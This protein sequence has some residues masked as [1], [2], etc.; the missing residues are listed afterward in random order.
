MSRFTFAHVADLHLDTPFSGL[1]ALNDAL[2]QQLQDASLLAWDRVVD[3]CLAEQVTFVVIAGDVYDSDTASVRAQLRF[4]RGLERLS[5]A[6]IPSF[7]VHG[8]HDPNGGRWSAVDRWPDGVTVF[9][10]QEVTHVPVVVGGQTVATVS[11]LSFPE[12]HVQDNLAR[13]FI[14]QDLPGYH[15]AVLHCNVDS[16][17]SHGVYAPCTLQDLRDSR[18]DYWALGHIHAR[19]ILHEHAPLVVYPGN[20]QARHPNETGPKGFALVDVEDGQA[21]VRWVEADSWRFER[22]DFSCAELASLAA[23]EEQL[24]LSA[25]AL[26]LDRPVVMRARLTGMTPLHTDLLRP[27][28]V[29]SLLQALRD[30]SPP[31]VWW[32]DLEIATRPLFNRDARVQGEDFTADV[33][34]MIDASDAQ[35]MVEELLG[36]IE[37]HPALIRARP[38]LDLDSLLAAAP[39]LLAEAERLA[40]ERLEGGAW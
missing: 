31:D 3:G 14:R 4:K 8:N 28:T 35:G 26:G 17:A 30:Q 24:L 2:A 39:E 10:T 33:L 20:T 38:V 1:A 11:G 12:R 5:D 34:R 6:G 23:L 22:L 21:G 32:D 13:R 15:V 29:G 27:G 16:D 40:I 37:R 36:E 19:R 18:Y 7:I 25:G 9:G